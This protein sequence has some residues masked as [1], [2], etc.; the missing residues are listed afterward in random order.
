MTDDFYKRVYD[1][2]RKIP[3]GKIA[4]YGQIAVM[5][6][7]PQA[8][9]TVGYALNALRGNMVFPPVPW[10]RVINYKGRISLPHGGGYE[11]QRD[12]L[13]EEGVVM[14]EDESYDFEKYGWKGGN[15]K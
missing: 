2:V 4:T 6:S 3:P 14:E 5:L 15:D 7:S 10:Q 9:R 13:A 12:L 1:L 11:M 8:A